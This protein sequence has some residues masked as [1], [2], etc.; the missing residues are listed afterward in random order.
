MRLAFMGSP[1]FAVP[2]LDALA[3]AGHGIACVY[4]QP[5]RP[6]GRGHKEHP[7][8]VHARALEMGLPVRTPASMRGADEAAAFRALDLDVCVTAAFGQ[9]LP[10]EI[11]GA[12]RLGCVNIH[13]SM[14][15]RWRGAAPVSR[16]IETGDTETGVTI[17]QMVE[18]LDAGP[19]LAR[20]AAPVGPD[21]DA[22]GLTENLSALGAR[23]IVPALAGLADGALTPEPQDETL[24]T[25]AEKIKKAEAKLDFRAPAGVLAR[26]VRAFNP[27]PGAWFRINGGPRIKVLAAQAEPDSGG[28]AGAGASGDAPG[29]IIDEKLGILTADG[30]FRPVRVRPEGGR[31]MDAE[32][33]LRGRPVPPGARAD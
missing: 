24:V 5:P 18:A 9:I 12:P 22:G 2:A 29:D 19:V 17:M 32:A 10:A 27:A 28:G 15:P 25:Y 4:S 23:M 16:A 20:E 8:P 30:I 26:R 3:R 11:L 33:F 13:A 1:A 14:L 21:D 31:E 7:C 6:K